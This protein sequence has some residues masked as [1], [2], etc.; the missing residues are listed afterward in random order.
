MTLY[1]DAE[2]QEAADIIGEACVRSAGVIKEHWGL[3]TP[4]DTRVYVLTSWPRFVLHSAPVFWWPLLAITLPWWVIRTSQRWKIARGWEQ[5]YW[6]RQAVGVKPPRLVEP[7]IAASQTAGKY[8]VVEQSPEELI[9]NTT[10][11]ELTHAFSAHLRLPMWLNEGL[12]MRTVDRLFDRPMVRLESLELLEHAAREDGPPGYAAI[13]ARDQQA[14]LYHYVRAYW[15]TRYVEETR[16][17]VLRSLLARRHGRQKIDESVAAAYGMRR[18]E[19][20][21]KADGTVAAHFRAPR[22]HPT[23]D[24]IHIQGRQK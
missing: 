5:N 9:M 11:H 13:D 15:T 17:A 6:T 2:E 21:S 20:W 10:G 18:G 1:Y 8:F 16:P 3:E 7:L 22:I 12:A 19:F 4:P 24:E 23:S 14:I